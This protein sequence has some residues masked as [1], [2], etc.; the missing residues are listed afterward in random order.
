MQSNQARVE[1]N[2]QSTEGDANVNDAWPDAWPLHAR[3]L[4]SSISQPASCSKAGVNLESN[5]GMQRPAASTTLSRDDDCYHCELA[6]LECDLS[7]S[8]AE[9]EV[10]VAK[11]CMGSTGTYEQRG[12]ARFALLISV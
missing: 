6:A 10:S 4:K 8:Y 5:V 11:L 2:V 7:L 9:I 1:N 12:K 3:N